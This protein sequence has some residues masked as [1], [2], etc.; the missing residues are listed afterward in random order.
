[1]KVA[2][3][4][5]HRRYSDTKATACRNTRTM[6]SISQKPGAT[7]TSS[8]WKPVAWSLMSVK[9]T[10]AMTRDAAAGSTASRHP[11]ILE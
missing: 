4:A 7:S 3:S 5:P 11:A 2:G 8:R 10:A 9:P 6:D 1:M